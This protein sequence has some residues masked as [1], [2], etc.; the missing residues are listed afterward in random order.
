MRRLP[1]L[2]AAI[3]C[4]LCFD[5]VGAQDNLVPLHVYG[6]KAEDLVNECMAV[7]RMDPATGT[8]PV[9]DAQGIGLCFGYLSVVV[10]V[11]NV[12]NVESPNGGSYCIPENASITQLAK[13][14]LK[15]GDDHPEI[16]NQPA[17]GLV[18]F[19]FVQSF[20]CKSQGQ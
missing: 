8:V 17:I 6:G 2:I 10:D 9:K 5:S 11:H 14:V 16:L 7:D 13:V 12:L 3:L 18:G 4:V 20:P 19:A 1:T 15:Y